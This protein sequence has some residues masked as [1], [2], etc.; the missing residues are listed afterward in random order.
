MAAEFSTPLGPL[1]VANAH[2]SYLPGVRERQ[3]RLLVR[4]LRG[5]AGPFVL[6]GDLNLRAPWPARVTRLQPLA[7]HLTFPAD[8]PNRQ[9]DHALT[10]GGVRAVRS[11]AVELGVSDHRAL[12]VDVRLTAGEG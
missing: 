4:R 12:V 11:R 8:R 3:L 5:V 9:I 6:L 1:T 7:R 10:G 2:L